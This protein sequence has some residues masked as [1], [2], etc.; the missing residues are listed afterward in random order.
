MV[1]KVNDSA[2]LTKV[3]TIGTK[4]VTNIISYLVQLDLYSAGRASFVVA[5]EQEPNGLVELHLGYKI[6]N[7]TPYFLGIIESKHQSNGQWFLTC[8]ELL[9]ALSFPAPIAIRF[10]TMLNVINEL[11]KIGLEFVYPTTFANEHDYIKTPVPCFYHQGDGISALRQLG[12]IFQVP[13]YIFQQRPDG[14]I[15]VGSWQDSG[16]A[17]SEINNFAEHPITVKSSNT[18][19]LITIPKL[20]PG[21]KLNG[22]Y[23]IETTLSGNKQVIRWSKTLYAA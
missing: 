8:R 19:E 3:L 12:K 22:R 21:I 7:L 23:I 6:D 5:C 13:D 17:K 10:A 20:R 4:P 15:Y 14:K 11:E 1:S 9:G 2:R 18:G 16:W